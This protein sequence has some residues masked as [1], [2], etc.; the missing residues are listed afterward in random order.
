VQGDVCHV[1]RVHISQ[2]LVSLIKDE[3]GAAVHPQCTRPAGS[4]GVIE[5]VLLQQSER[6][7]LQQNERVL[8][9]QSESGGCQGSTMTARVRVAMPSACA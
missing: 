5:R 3:A 4:A 1:A 6:V 8:L 9:Q 2:Q 7:L